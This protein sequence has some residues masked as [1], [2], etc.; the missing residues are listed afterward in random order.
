VV[1]ASASNGASARKAQANRV[2]DRLSAYELEPVFS[3]QPSDSAWQRL[4]IVVAFSCQPGVADVPER[5]GF[6]LLV[7][8]FSYQQIVNH[9][10]S[11]LFLVT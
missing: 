8:V 6:H 9:D 4:L 5:P 1:A 11:H 10:D 7:I 2:E 3:H